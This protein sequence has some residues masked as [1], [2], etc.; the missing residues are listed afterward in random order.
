M[1]GIKDWFG[2]GKKESTSTTS[3]PTWLEHGSQFAVERS[4]TI[5]DREYIPYATE[6]RF[7]DKSFLEQ[8][9][10][11]VYLQ[12]RGKADADLDASRFY[13]G[14][15]AQDF[16]S[17][18]MGSYMNPYIEGALDPTVR[19]IREEQYRNEDR[20]GQ[21]AGMAGAF[22]GSRGAILET[23]ATRGGLEEIGDTYKEGFASAFES[24]RDQFNADRDAS[25]RASDQFKGI[26]HEQRT[27][28]MS[29]VMQL[30]ELG[31]LNRG[32]EQ[33]DM[34]FDFQ[35]FLEAR[36]WDINNLQPLLAAV[37]SVPSSTTTKQEST[38]GSG[39]VAG[40]I[41]GV[42]AL[43]AS[44]YFTGGATLAVAAGAGAA[45]NEME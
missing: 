34:D 25:A 39:N 27:G 1:G 4:Q 12:E 18:D 6:D 2:G 29:D 45:A 35:Q 14:E 19:E 42:A 32:L 40:K 28:L 41:I 5:A 22:G 31:Q 33:A 10:E 20:A 13:A 3:I 15:G 37:G 30:Q 17:A 44:A 24:A 23:E 16:R 36:D 8:G 7:A 26:S 11:D 21:K 9:A 43:V 38:A